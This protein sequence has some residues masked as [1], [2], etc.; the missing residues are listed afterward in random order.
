MDR[1]QEERARNLV[2]ELKKHSTDSGFCVIG[3]KVV[4]RRPAAVAIF[5]DAPTTYDETDL[6]N[7]IEL[8]LLEKNQINGFVVNGWE[9]YQRKKS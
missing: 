5:Q 3:G 1:S 9:R 2:D 8:G 7:A 6:K 4:V